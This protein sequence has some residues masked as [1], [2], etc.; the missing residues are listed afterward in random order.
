MSSTKRRP[1]C[2]GLNVLTH[3]GRDKIVLKDPIYNITTLAQIMAW[4]LPGDEPLSE[5]NG[6]HFVSDSMCKHIE[7]ETK[8]VAKGPIWNITALAQIMA[9]HLPGDKPLTEPMMM[10]IY[11]RIHVTR[12]QRGIKSM[13]TLLVWWTSNEKRQALVYYNKAFN[14]YTYKKKTEQSSTLCKYTLHGHVAS[15]MHTKWIAFHPRTLVDG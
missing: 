9:W 14:E 15:C 11:W 4:H 13:S 2:L 5:R 8:F 10:Y 1:F 3:W 12:P 7:A 6:G